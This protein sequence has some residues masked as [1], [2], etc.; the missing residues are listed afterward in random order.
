VFK[1]RSERSSEAIVAAAK[2]VFL[3]EGY[4]A[5][6]D[7]IIREADIAR[8]TLYNHFEDK[9][10][11]F[12]AVIEAVALETMRELRTLSFTADV[13]L[14]EALRRFGDA[15]MQGMLHPENLAMTRLIS[16]A[17]QEFP[18]AGRIAYQVGSERSI[19]ALA[20]YL[21]GQRKAGNIRCPSPELIAE[22]FFGALVGPAR[23]R[24]LLGINVETSAAQR[25]NYVRE[26]V[27]L[28]VQG[29]QYRA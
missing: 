1:N 29:L 14:P 23:F 12:K 15:Y 17:V 13:Q 2:S 3:R 16:S 26:I 10:A 18:A 8:Q 11:L 21:D 28:Y 24:Y 6:I 4:Q 19:A 25:R 22:S 27:N 20:A 5:S 7:T 9:K